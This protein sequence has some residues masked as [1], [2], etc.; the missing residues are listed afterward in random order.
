MTN[1]FIKETEKQMNAT[2]TWNGAKAYSSTGSACVDLFGSVASSRDNVDGAV[3]KFWKAYSEDPETALRIL[4]W[5][6]DVRGGEGERAVPRAIFKSMGDKKVTVAKVLMDLI[7]VYGRWDDLLAFYKTKVWNVALDAICTQFEADISAVKADKNANVSLLAKWLPS[8]NASNVLR[9]EIGRVIAAKMNMTEKQYRK[10]V[11]AL[12][13]KIAIVEQL[14][15]SK[16]WDK[17]DYEKLPSRAAFMYRKAFAN[18]DS[19]RYSSYLTKVEKGEAKINSGTLYPYDI[20]KNYL[21]SGWYGRYSSMGVDRTLEAQWKALPNYMEGQDF[22]GLVVTDVSGSMYSTYGSST[23][24]PIDVSVSLAIYI[25]ERNQTEAWKNK[26]ITFSDKPRVATVSGET[27]YEK[28]KNILNDS[29]GYSTNIQ[30]VFDTVLST[31]VEAN[32][33][34]EDMPKNLFIISDMQFNHSQFSGKSMTNFE[35][36][37]KKYAEAGYKLP[38]LVFW[39][40]NAA[41]NV[42]I[43]IDDTGTCLVSGASASKVKSLLSGKEYTPV[44][45]MRDVVYAERYNPVGEKFIKLK[46]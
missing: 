15:C 21:S 43:T 3:K 40:V 5:A 29:M 45:V 24:R 32:L 20:V 28:V 27:L 41:D 8:I 46:S 25:A 35:V 12:R 26:F 4:F 13:S 38:Q 22:N 7:P 16:N 33:S 1:I 36:M 11:S 39:N 6:R 18:H 14:L 19:A 31:A 9:K 10:I 42:P 37:Q 44:Q 2:T 34:Q 17:V 23:I 30:A